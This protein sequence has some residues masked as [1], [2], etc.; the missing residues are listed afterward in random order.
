MSENEILLSTTGHSEIASK[1]MGTPKL[2]KV[3]AVHNP[4]PFIT[5]DE[6]AE[7]ILALTKLN[8]ATAAPIVREPVTLLF[9]R[10]I[11]YLTAAVSE[12]EWESL[13]KPEVNVVLNKKPW[14]I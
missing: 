3:R 8:W 14:F 11:A 1:R 7:Q 12:Q 5:L 2:L 9:S 13:N 4:E 6:I 10:E